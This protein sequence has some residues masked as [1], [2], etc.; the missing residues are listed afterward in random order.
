MREH[1]HL[2]WKTIFLSKKALIGKKVF[3]CENV[4]Q[5]MVLEDELPR[6][7]FRSDEK[8][9]RIRS[10]CDFDVNPP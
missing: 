1:N 7:G 3:Q 2:I 8:G 10:Q 4:C 9:M 6:A 5:E